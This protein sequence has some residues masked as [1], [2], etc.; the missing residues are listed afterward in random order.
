MSAP[1]PTGAEIIRHWLAT[2]PFVAHLAIRL[3]DIQ[4]GTATLTL[5]YSGTMTTIGTVVHGGAIATLIDTAAAAAAWSD[6]AVPANIRGTTVNVSVAYLSAAESE[7]IMAVARVLSR[8]RTLVY[9][10][11]DVRTVSGKAVAK[12]L[13]TYKLG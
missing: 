2:S 13:A 11:V 10:E 5:P 8:G 12:G 3:D 4:P 9:L 6:A 1:T 7:D